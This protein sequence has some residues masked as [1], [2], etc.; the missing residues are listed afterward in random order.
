MLLGMK[1]IHGMSKSF[2]STYTGYTK[3]RGCLHCSAVIDSVLG[4]YYS[5]YLRIAQQNLRLLQQLPKEHTPGQ[6][7]QTPHQPMCNHAQSYISSAA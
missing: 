1:Q 5:N 4:I 3:G 7:K 2:L 6:D